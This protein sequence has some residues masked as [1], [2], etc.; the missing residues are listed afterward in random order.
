MGGGGGDGSKKRKKR[1]RGRRRRKKTDFCTVHFFFNNEEERFLFSESKLNL[2]TILF[3]Y[4]PT[5][6]NQRAETARAKGQN[7]FVSEKEEAG[8]REK[9][10]SHCF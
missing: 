5:V 8:E 3:I 4:G 10:E 7:F 6:H 2:E 1:K 9:D